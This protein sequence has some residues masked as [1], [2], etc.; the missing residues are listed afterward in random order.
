MVSRP[1]SI[2]VVGWLATVLG[3]FSLVTVPFTFLLTGTQRF[4]ELSPVPI[5]LQL[6]TSL[7]GCLVTVI[8]G[9]AFLKGKDWGRVLYLGFFTAS[10]AYSLITAPVKAA[11]IPSVAILGGMIFVLYRKPARLFFKGRP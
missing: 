7:L 1:T 6:A 8:C 11:V 4:A 10:L 9:V 3:T 5:E 2:T